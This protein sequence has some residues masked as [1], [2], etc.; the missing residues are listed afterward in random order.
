LLKCDKILNINNEFIGVII[1]KKQR[2]AQMADFISQKSTVTLSELADKFGVTIFTV[3]RD[4]EELVDKGIVKKFYGG[5]SFNNNS[6]ATLVE[7]EGRNTIHHEQKLRIAKAVAQEIED[8]DV[9]FIDAG[10]T[11]MYISDY[12]KDKKLTVFTNNIYVIIKLFLQEN[13]NLFVIGGELDHRTKSLF[14]LNALRFLDNITIHKAFLGTSG[15]SLENGFTNYTFSESE[16]KS[17]VIGISKKSYILA[18]TSKFDKPSM[19]RFARFED[20]SCIATCKT[21]PQKYI[22][23][24]NK[25]K[26]E[27]IYG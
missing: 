7:F 2:L 11:T 27:I 19:I 4:V 18:D 14:G 21:I 23:Y 20:I 9:I 10:T 24:S 8:N 16:I 13:I 15:I 3:R 25:N 5:V 22:D 1:L 12:I 26:I 17:K 6:V